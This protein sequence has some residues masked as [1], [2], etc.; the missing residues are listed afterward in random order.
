MYEAQAEE[1]FYLKHGK[2]LGE[3]TTAAKEGKTVQTLL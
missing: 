2:E 1:S 3:L